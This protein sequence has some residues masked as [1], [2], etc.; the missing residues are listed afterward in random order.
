MN[1][2][3]YIKKKRGLGC[4]CALGRATGAG[5]LEAEDSLETAPRHP[6]GP[7]NPKPCSETFQESRNNPKSC[8]ESLQ[9][10]R[11]PPNLSVTEH[12]CA[13]QP[14]A[15]GIELQGAGWQQRHRQH[16]E[17]DLDVILPFTLIP[18]KNQ[19]YKI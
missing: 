2:E 3:A 17:A 6:P 16:F 8:S 4:G 14:A 13:P 18:Y 5:P 11:H 9:E 10:A 7:N 19:R 15:G 1:P 12:L